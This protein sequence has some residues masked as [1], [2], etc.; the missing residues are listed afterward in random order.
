MN[1]IIGHWSFKA[2]WELSA[3]ITQITFLVSPIVTRFVP[4]YSSSKCG[5]ISS[6]FSPFHA[7]NKGNARGTRPND[8]LHLAL[9]HS[10]DAP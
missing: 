1:W 7:N 6:Y 2:P 10:C 4:F 5:G 3:S 8:Y 9:R